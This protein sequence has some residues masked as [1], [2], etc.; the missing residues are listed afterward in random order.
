MSS[1]FHLVLVPHDET[2]LARCLRGSTFRY[3]QQFNW[4]HGRS[5]RLWQN[6]YFSCPVDF[7]SHLWAVA[8]YV[9]RNPARAKLVDKP[10]D[11]R[12]SSAK[13]HIEGS[14]DNVLSG[15]DWLTERERSIYQQFLTEPGM[16]QQIRQ[17]SSTGR[18]LGNPAFFQQLERMLKRVLQPQSIGRPRQQQKHD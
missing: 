13:A 16:E 5:G 1:H 10:E 4:R 17:A 15:A 2:S 8:R 6:R 11:W 12:W 3:A 7:G 18:P 9:E 14:D